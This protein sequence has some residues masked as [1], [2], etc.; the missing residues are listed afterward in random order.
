M[1]KPE[2]SHTNNL[3]A[4]LKTWKR[5]QSRSISEQSTQH[6]IISTAASLQR[7]E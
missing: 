2:Q 1:L 7:N 6:V 4:F 5:H 3:Q